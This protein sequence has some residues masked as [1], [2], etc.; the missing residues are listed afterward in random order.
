MDRPPPQ[1]TAEARQR[2]ALETA[3]KRS[4]EPCAHHLE[5]QRCTSAQPVFDLGIATNFSRSRQTQRSSGPMCCS[6]KSRLH[7]SACAVSAG[8][9]ANRGVDACLDPDART[10]RRTRS[11][12]N[13]DP[14][15][16]T[17]VSK[18]AS[19]KLAPATHG[20]T[21]LPNPLS[22][23]RRRTRCLSLIRGGRSRAG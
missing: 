21:H 7:P 8:L 2:S 17:S 4:G 10:A 19:S 13:Q 11:H 6:K 15:A 23:S 1:A 9:S 20:S 12:A 14:S 18:R 22:R 3:W 16:A 5:R